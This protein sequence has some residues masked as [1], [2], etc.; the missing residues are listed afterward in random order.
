MTFWTCFWLFS[1]IFVKFQKFEFWKFWKKNNFRA[2]IRR[3]ENGCRKCWLKQKFLVFIY[4]C[5]YIQKIFP[6][7][8]I[9]ILAGGQIVAPRIFNAILEP[10]SVKV[11]NLSLNYDLF[12]KRENRRK[13]EL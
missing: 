7:S 6:R 2:K 3:S 11:N 5:V 8:K 12:R 10:A 9:V 1:N 13:K 4:E